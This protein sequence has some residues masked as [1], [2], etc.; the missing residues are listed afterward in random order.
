MTAVFPSGFNSC[1]TPF[2]SNIRELVRTSGVA[3]EGLAD[4]VSRVHETSAS[5]GS[6]STLNFHRDIISLKFSQQS[7]TW[8]AR[9]AI[10]GFA[11]IPASCRIGMRMAHASRSLP[12]VFLNVA[13]TADGKIAPANRRFVPFGSRRYQIHMLE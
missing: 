4:R 5:S 9:H 13:I 7:K 1:T 10:K 6:S 8:Q 11:S 12:F 2:T 3:A